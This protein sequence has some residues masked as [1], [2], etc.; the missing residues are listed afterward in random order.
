MIWMLIYSFDVGHQSLDL[1]S[2]EFHLWVG[3]RTSHVARLNYYY[4]LRRDL[5]KDWHHFLRVR[6]LIWGTRSKAVYYVLC[7]AALLFLGFRSEETT[8][9]RED[10]SLGLYIY[11]LF[12]AL[13]LVFTLLLSLL[14]LTT[15]VSTF[16]IELLFLLF[17]CSIVCFIESSGLSLPVF[18]IFRISSTFYLLFL[19]LCLKTS[20]YSYSSS[21]LLI[22]SITLLIFFGKVYI[23]LA[24]DILYLS[25]IY[26]INYSISSYALLYTCGDR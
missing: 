11:D 9:L 24:I 3:W 2:D 18:L 20:Q 16:P 10:L 12:W 22:T 8:F 17:L 25:S 23:L 19:Y 26:A 7:R 14:I 21:L 6:I 15:T 4:K 13:C 5:R 1:R